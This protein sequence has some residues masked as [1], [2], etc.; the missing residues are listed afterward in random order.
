MLESIGVQLYSTNLA[1]DVQAIK[2]SL[3]MAIVQTLTK[4]S[5]IDAFKHSSR[6]DQFSYEALEAIFEYMEE[7]S[8]NTGESIELDIVA[9][10]CEWS[11][12]HW[13]DIARDYSIDLNDF[14]DDEDDDERIQAVY[15]TISEQT[16]MLDLGNGNFVFVQF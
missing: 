6:K 5:F 2:W 15:E 3:T 7:Y 4:S 12:S 8:A 14:A 16:T 13:S 11:E 10:C 9:I 1:C